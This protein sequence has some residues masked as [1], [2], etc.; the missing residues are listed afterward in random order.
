MPPHISAALSKPTGRCPPGIRRLR[1]TLDAAGSETGPP[2]A[3]AFFS[4]GDTLA[5]KEPLA[6]WQRYP[7]LG[8]FRPAHLQVV[9]IQLLDSTRFAG[10]ELPVTG[11]PWRSKNSSRVRPDN[12]VRPVT[13]PPQF[14]DPLHDLTLIVHARLPPCLPPDGGHGGQGDP[15]DAPT[16]GPPSRQALLHVLDTRRRPRPSPSRET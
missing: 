12:G 16:P 10:E 11:V 2:S 3:K 14:L 5:M 8:L 13:S 4:Q 7:E 15:V 9:E 1:S 6:V